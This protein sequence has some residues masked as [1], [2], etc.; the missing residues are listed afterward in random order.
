[1]KYFFYSFLFLLVACTKEKSGHTSTFIKNTTTHTIKLLPYKGA[2]IDMSYAKTIP[3]TSIIEVYSANVWGKTIDPCF[4]TLLQP[5]DSV[6]VKF[7]DTVMIPHIKFNLVYNGTHYIP[8]QSNRSISNANS[9]LKEIIEE[10][11]RSITGKFT[12]TFTEQDYLD[13]R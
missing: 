5:Y 11:K 13:A 8:F 6:V 10:A 3:A 1:M 9:Y 12:Y 7:D 2:S 4:G